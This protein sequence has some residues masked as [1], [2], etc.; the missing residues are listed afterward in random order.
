MAT[1]RRIV[2]GLVVV[3]GFVMVLSQ[4]YS[5]SSRGDVNEMTTGDQTTNNEMEMLDMMTAEEETEV[6]EMFPDP[7]KDDLK[8]ELILKALLIL[9]TYEGHSVSLTSWFPSYD[10]MPEELKLK[11]ILK[12]IILL[13][14]RPI[15][16]LFAGHVVVE[17][18]LTLI[19]KAILILEENQGDNFSL[20][21]DIEDLK[22]ALILK[23]IDVLEIYNGDYKDTVF[24]T[25]S[26]E[27]LKL[28]LILKAI[29]LLKQ[30]NWP[31]DVDDLWP[32]GEE[33][34]DQGS[35]DSQSEAPTLETTT[36][37]AET[38]E[39][40]STSRPLTTVADRGV[41]ESTKKPWL[42]KGISKVFKWFKWIPKVIHKKKHLIFH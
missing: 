21:I 13:K 11:L 4:A 15:D 17:L 2:L 29:T 38:T 10:I 35:E 42:K 27:D 33:D 3:L 36:E 14:N 34:E 20:S 19:L 16:S 32:M 23:A 39:E 24:F 8:L 30:G 37:G 7:M 28:A 40:A 26:K 6:D 9:K 12:A 31:I 22:L 18:K 1:M 41:D 25:E 5:I